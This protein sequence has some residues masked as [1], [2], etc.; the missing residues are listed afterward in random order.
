MGLVIYSLPHCPKCKV[1]LRYL[2]S[3]KIIYEERNAQDYV[4]YLMSHGFVAAPVL[5]VNGQLYDFTSINQVILILR[6]N[7]LIT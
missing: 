6:D 1:L 7:G 3:M 2:D 4:A 5:E